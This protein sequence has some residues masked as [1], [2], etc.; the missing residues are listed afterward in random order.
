MIDRCNLGLVGL[1][2]VLNRTGLFYNEAITLTAEH[3]Y[4]VQEFIALTVPSRDGEYMG[5]TLIPFTLRLLTGSLPSTGCIAC[6]R[7][8]DKCNPPFNIQSLLCSIN[9]IAS[10]TVMLTFKGSDG[11]RSGGVGL[12]SHLC[13]TSNPQLYGARSNDEFLITSKLWIIM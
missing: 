9:L 2:L 11:V 3:S 7:A 6:M 8:G 13:K 1:K 5:R 12:L 10:H 4:S